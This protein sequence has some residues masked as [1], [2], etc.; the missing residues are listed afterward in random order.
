[1]S[2]RKKRRADSAPMPGG[3]VGLLRFYQEETHGIKLRPEI[4]VGLAVTLT[5]GVL[6]AQIYA[7][8]KLPFL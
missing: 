4:V 6:L 2:K 7:I 5:L 8:G 1:M 3:S